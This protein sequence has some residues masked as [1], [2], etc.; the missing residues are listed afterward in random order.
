MQY[1]ETLPRPIK[2]NFDRLRASFLERYA[3]ANQHFFRR[4]Q[5]TTR[6]MKPGEKVTDYSLALCNEARKLELQDNEIL[7]LFVQGLQDDIKEHV[8]L[9][10]PVTLE[11]AQTAVIAKESAINTIQKGA[12]KVDVQA[13]IPIMEALILILG[14]LFHLT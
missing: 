10:A 12:T 8:L 7:Q 13:L 2:G 4:Q 14:L 5:F 9:Q 3:P 1:Y 11:A 6:R